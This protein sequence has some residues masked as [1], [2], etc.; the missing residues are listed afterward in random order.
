MK[1]CLLFLLFIS[2]SGLSFSQPT[3]RTIADESLAAMD[4]VKTLKY[5]LVK[6][7][8]IKGVMK[9]S[10]IQVKYQRNPFKIYIYVYSPKP[11]VEILYN[12]GEN[13]NKAHINPNHFFLNMLDPNL[14]PMGK[15]LRKDEHH[16]LYETGFEFTRLLLTA[17]KKRADEEKNFDELCK[18]VGEITWANRPCYKLLLSYPN[19]TWEEYTVKKGE[20]LIEIAKN[21]NLNEYMILEKNKLS[22]YD[23]V[24][25]GQKILIPNIFAKKV[26]LYIDK[27]LK[28]PI[29]QE[30]YDDVGL[31]EV[32]EYHG[33]IVNPSIQPEEFTKKYK[34]YKF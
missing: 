29:Y 9:E 21:K 7:E 12:H 31:F 25:E 11:G 32:Y 16:T 23:K 3:S 28:L 19:F 33:V 15:T 4:R 27:I 22:W 17:L 14:D 2:V 10:E 5:R 18:Y 13:G 24:S 1:R 6:K 8:R 26:I 30:V 34:E 20:T